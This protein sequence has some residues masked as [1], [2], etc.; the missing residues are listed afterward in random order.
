MERV[1][2]ALDRIS[3]KIDRLM[4]M[5]ERI[6]QLLAES[7]APRRVEKPP[8]FRGAL[9]VM[10]LLALP[11]HLR[12]SAM[13]VCEANGGATADEVAERTGRARAVESGYLNQLVAMG[14]LG[15][16]RKGRRVYFYVV[17]GGSG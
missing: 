16:R 14:H 6:L 9:D 13:V 10:T 3:S 2:E 12:K 17:E 11:D 1:R 4:E 15:K 7:G 5:D 8:E